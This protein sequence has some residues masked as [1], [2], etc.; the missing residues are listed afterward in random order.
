MSE[1]DGLIAQVQR[2]REALEKLRREVDAMVVKG[3]SRANE[4]QAS[5]RGDGRL[6]ELVI[7][8]A[9]LRRNDAHDLGVIVTEAVNNALENLAKAT[10]ARFEPVVA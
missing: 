5:V 8:P 9:A 2:Q 3:R 7:D 1:F 10:K 6:A 4:V